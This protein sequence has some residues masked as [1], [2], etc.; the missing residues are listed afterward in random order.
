MPRFLVACLAVLVMGAAGCASAA[1]YDQVYM[2]RGIASESLPAPASVAKAAV[3]AAADA[4][5]RST[6]AP[7]T[8]DAGPAVV[9]PTTALQSR[10]IIYTGLF[11]VLVRRIDDA[12]EATRRMAEKAGGYV[13]S[14]KGPEIVVRVPAA[15]FNDATASLAELGQI[16]SKE[17]AAQDVTESYADLEVRIKTAKA[18]LDEFAKLLEKS[19]NVE[20]ALLVEREMVRVRAEIERMEAQMVRLSSEVNYATLTVRFT[21]VAPPVTP[22]E[23]RVNLP[24]PW[25]KQ[26]G[27]DSLMK[28][29]GM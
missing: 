5:P 13:Q 1:K 26:L 10:K 18:M 27:L 4:A 15:K 8:G 21:Q 23:L 14:M 29:V 7:K 12:L 25:L 28:I 19:A 17:I 6:P 24:V 20:E 11:S 16:L 22:P 2:A 3:P 9:E